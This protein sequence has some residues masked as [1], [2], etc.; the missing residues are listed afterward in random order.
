M[1]VEEERKVVEE[2]KEV[3]EMEEVEV[4][5]EK[6]EIKEVDVSRPKKNSVPGRVCVPHVHRKFVGIA[7][8]CTH[9]LKDFSKNKKT[10][11]K[12]VC[13]VKERIFD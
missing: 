8:S 1:V 9:F 10:A 2:F 5:E 6:E 4:V 13:P 7:A 11:G 3:E 12:H